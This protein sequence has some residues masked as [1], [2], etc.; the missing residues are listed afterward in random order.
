MRKNLFVILALAFT[1]VVLFSSCKKDGERGMNLSP[2]NWLEGEFEKYTKLNRIY[3]QPKTVV[4]GTKG[5][6]SGSSEPISVHA[7]LEALKKGGSAAD[8]VMTTAL[9][10]ICQ[11]MGSYVSYAG[12]MSMVYYD[13][14][15]GKVHSMN[16]SY[17]TVLEEDDPLSIPPLST[18]SGRSALVPGFMAGVQAAHDRF[19]KIPFDQL[20]EPAV[21]LADEGFVLDSRAAGRIKGR[22]DVLSRFPETKKIFT[23]DNG[24]FYEKGDLFKQPEL[25]ATL[26]KVA[27]RG[28]DYIY[29]GEWAKKFV[30]AVRR[31]GGKMTFGDLENYEVLWSEALP[32]KYG[33]Y[34]VYSMALP[35]YGGLAV[36]ESFNLLDIANLAQ[37]GHYASS[38]EALY[39]F[40]QIVRVNGYLG[41]SESGPAFGLPIASEIIQKY[42]PEGDI[43]L[44]SRTRKETAELVWDKMNKPEWENLKD[45]VLEW[46]IKET[47]HIWEGLERDLKRPRHSA[48]IAAIDQWGNFCAIVHSINTI[49]WGTT[50]IFVDGISIPDSAC[51][52]QP[53]I[54]EVGPGVRLPDPQNPT[55]VLKEGKPVLACSSIGIGLNEVTIQSILNVIDFDMDPQAAVDAPQFLRPPWS[56]YEFEKQCVAAGVFS[57]EILEAVKKMGQDFKI[58]SEGIGYWV[59]VK[60]EQKTGKL[61]GGVSP[62]LNGLAEGY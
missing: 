37:H 18:P 31:D 48:C 45:E 8:A 33:D 4:E 16:S 14:S 38:P 59:G 9:A 21:Y 29:K 62:Q 36:I 6:I 19:G 35:N 1:L 20:F 26:R 46:S 56:P 57:E 25:A 40:I 55:I 32:A 34:E 2:A 3:G 11:A 52:Q 5:I 28:A 61:Q 44:E 27:S 24:E 49:N 30:E 58:S 47:A 23:G 7:G 17:N 12:H 13:A 10:Q 41:P 22:K 50:G 42:F 43:S 60:I 39:W 53:I 51:F 54:K 15:T